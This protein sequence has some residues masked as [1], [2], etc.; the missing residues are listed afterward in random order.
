MLSRGSRAALAVLAVAA[1]AFVGSVQSKK[2]ATVTNKVGI[3]VGMSYALYT[4][5]VKTYGF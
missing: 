1:V 3:I 4:V 5:G 2:D